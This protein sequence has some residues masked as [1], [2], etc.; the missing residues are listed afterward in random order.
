MAGYITSQ[1]IVANVPTYTVSM[2]QSPKQLEEHRAAALAYRT[3]L[4]ELNAI[5]Q[6]VEKTSMQR[7]IPTSAHNALRKARIHRT[8]ATEARSFQG[9]TKNLIAGIK[10]ARF[11]DVASM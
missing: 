1:Q 11:A 10:A 3:I 7:R 8:K 6:S 5:I 2:P 9:K 4:N